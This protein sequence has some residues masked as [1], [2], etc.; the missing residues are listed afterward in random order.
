MKRIYKPQEIYD[1]LLEHY[2]LEWRFFLVDDDD[3][4]RC[5]R[6]NDFKGDKLS[7]SAIMWQNGKRKTIWLDVSNTEL[8]IMGCNIEPVLSWSDYLALRHHEER[9]L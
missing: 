6:K 9:S 3:M 2:G 7:T 5:V 4:Y 8:F 1:Y